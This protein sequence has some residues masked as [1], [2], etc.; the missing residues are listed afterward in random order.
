MSLEHTIPFAVGISIYLRYYLLIR[1]NAM[2][3]NKKFAKHNL[4]HTAI[5]F[6]M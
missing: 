5:I 6:K 3:F 4:F 1:W 2:D